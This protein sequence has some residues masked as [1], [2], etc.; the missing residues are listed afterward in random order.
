MRVKIAPI[1]AA[2]AATASSWPDAE[3]DTPTTRHRNR[4]RARSRSSIRPPSTPPTSA[5]T[6]QLQLTTIGDDFRG[7]SIEGQ[8]MPEYVVNPIEID[9]QLTDLPEM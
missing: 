5:L 3:P 8:R 1:A 6:P 7:R 9:P 2:A 4:R